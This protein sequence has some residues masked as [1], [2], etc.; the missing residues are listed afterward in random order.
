M[1]TDKLLN[2]IEHIRSLVDDY[3]NSET[4]EDD[5]ILDVLDLIYEA[6]W[7]GRRVEPTGYYTTLLWE[8]MKRIR[9]LIEDS[10]I[11]ED[12]GAELLQRASGTNRLQA[13]RAGNASAATVAV[14]PI[15]W[16]CCTHYTPPARWLMRP[17]WATDR[18]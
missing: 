14:Y 18:E 11:I 17:S 9:S 8:A 4:T 7:H 13:R 12:P 5:D 6:A 15:G 10:E 3:R 2:M 1:T 16:T